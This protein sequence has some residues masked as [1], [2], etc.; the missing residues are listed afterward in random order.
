[1]LSLLLLVEVLVALLS[2]LDEPELDLT[3]EFWLS[4]LDELELERVVVLFLLPEEL[5]VLT[6]APLLLLDELEPER[7]VALFL[8]SEELSV[9]TAEPLLLLEE[10]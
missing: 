8:L 1:M 2:P 7:V 4:L 6:A 10:L 5:S 3:E 9:L